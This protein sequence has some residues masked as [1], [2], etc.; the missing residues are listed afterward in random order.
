LSDK[1]LKQLK[2]TCRALR[3]ID[4]IRKQG[5][6]P[7]RGILLWG[8]PGTGK[9]QIART[10][11]NESG[12]GFVA[13]RPSDM[14]A[15]YEGQS[16][17]KVHELFERAR[18]HAP[19]ILFIDEVDAAFPKRGGD[20]AGHFNTD[21]V[22][23]ALTEMDGIAKNERFVFLLAAT[24]RPDLIDDAILER[25]PDVIEIP[26][27][28][29]QQRRQILQVL[30]AKKRVDFDVQ[31]VTAELAGMTGNFSGRALRSLVEKAT[32]AAMTRAFENE[33]ESD[34][35]S[36]IVSREDLLGQLPSIPS[37]ADAARSGL[38]AEA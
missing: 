2:S 17:P 10:M 36:I 12:V 13:A 3:Q 24:N 20:Q 23:Q 16:A 38:P 5:A 28:D 34:E 11:A 8:K 18:N 4:S 30:L 6:D 21:I 14:K 29:A 9:T 1:L 33:P 32:G 15:G 7:P 26:Y 22:N 35:V 19:C 37:P 27:P 31:Q 25:F